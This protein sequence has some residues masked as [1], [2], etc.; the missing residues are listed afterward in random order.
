MTDEHKPGYAVDLAALRE[1]AQERDWGKL[2]TALTR[3][4]MEL[5]FYVALEMTISRIHEHL[6]V[7]ERAHPGATWA[8][9]LLVG[10][11]S[12]GIAPPELP[13]EAGEPHPSPGAANT[14]MALFELARG[15]ERKTP[16]D[17]RMRFLANAL[18]NIMLADL[19]SFWYGQH[20]EAWEQQMQHGE[21]INPTTGFSVRQQIYA[22]FWLDE[23]TA[24]RDTTNWLKLAEQLEH[25][26]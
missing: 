1:A 9:E 18:A 6:P 5:D 7:F 20:P 26:L 13:P 21:E 17:N 8:R 15:A 24:E 11:V 10:L 23:T 2:Q 22:Q 14:I 3:L 19:A 16:L 12:Y 4:M 25:K